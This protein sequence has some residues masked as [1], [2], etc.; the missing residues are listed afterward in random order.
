[1]KIKNAWMVIGQLGRFLGQTEVPNGAVLV[2][3]LYPRMG[4]L[5]IELYSSLRDCKITYLHDME[6][7]MHFTRNCLIKSEDA[8]KLLLYIF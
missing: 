5:F 2:I 7:H 6:Q 4:L 8:P 1:M 3:S